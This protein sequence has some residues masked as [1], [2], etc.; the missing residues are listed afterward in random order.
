[1]SKVLVRAL[2]VSGL[3][4]LGIMIGVVGGRLPV[5]ASMNLFQNNTSNAAA[6]GDYCHF[7]E[8]T[9]ANNLHVIASDLEQAS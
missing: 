9:L 1:M 8:M 2:M 7:Y 4:L 3:L 5:F 6:S